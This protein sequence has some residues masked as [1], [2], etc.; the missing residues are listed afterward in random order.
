MDSSRKIMDK[1]TL[2]L[3]LQYEHCIYNRKSERTPFFAIS[4]NQ[5]LWKHISL[6]RKC[7]YY[8]NTKKRIRY[9]FTKF[10]LSRIQNKHAIHVPLN[11]FDIGLRIVHV[12]PILINGAVKG[13]KNVRILPNA[14]VVAGGTNDSAPI[15][16]DGIIIGVGAVILGSINVA[17]YVAIGANSVVN[18]SVKEAGIT[19]AGA[20]ARKVS[21]NSSRDWDK[22]FWRLAEEASVIIKEN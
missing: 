21:N 20:P 4:E 10:R 17:D 13:G 16:G 1:K 15:L 12:A 14:S 6:L 18:K 19:V 11:A 22:N 9:L 2:N 7:E 5:I 3:F 8:F